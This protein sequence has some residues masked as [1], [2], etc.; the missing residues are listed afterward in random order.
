MPWYNAGTVSVTND[1]VNVTGAGTAWV[2]N[3]RAGQSFVG[4]DG[5]TIEIASVVSATSLTLARPYRGVTAAGQAYS[6]M[7][8]QGDLRDLALQAK[9]LVLSFSSV[10]DGVG[11][12]IFPVGTVGTPGIR[13][14]GDEDTGLSRTAANEL[15]GI[16]GGAVGWRLTTGGL[17]VTGAV[18]A[19]N[20]GGGRA[21]LS[22]G[23]ATHTGFLALYAANDVRRGYIG[24]ITTTGGAQPLSYQ[25]E[26][27]GVHL[28]AQG[29]TSS[30]DI[31]SN[32][33][34][35]RGDG[36]NA[37]VRPTNAG[38]DLCLGA[39]ATTTWRCA[40]S[41][42]FHPEVD[43]VWS[44]GRADKR[45]SVFF[46]GTGSINTSDEREKL[47][48][49]FSEDLKAKF[50]RIADAI[51]RELGWFQLLD[52]IEE[53]GE[54]G[55]RWHFGVRAQRVWSIVA[56]EGL[57]A[58]LIGEGA[59]QRPDPSWTGSPP[60]A[61]LCWDIWPDRFDPIME[62]RQVGTDT[63]V[64]GQ[65]PT[66]LLDATGSP[67]MRNLIEERP[68]MGMVEVGQRLDRAAGNR[69]GLRVDQMGL[70]LNWEMGERDKDRQAEV[71]EFAVRLEALEAA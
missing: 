35:L 47:W 19:K 37:F 11:Q 4:P 32:N 22:P 36:S 69:F 26:T 28:F 46:A 57:C 60:P 6:I 42:V 5:L 61:W 53:K 56:A 58:P 48:R 70:L 23:D 66:G 15:S 3:V 34:L 49:G 38:G 13:F 9:D 39:N 31:Q 44:V 64:V 25:N 41:G 40:N 7:P 68:I 54:D 65:E 10:R 24:F 43:N 27:G 71:A 55:A 33:L 8:V 21:D 2:D 59:E 63:V 20:A 17:A 14:S 1:S 45:A 29:I 67:I 51:I 30:S 16:V 12:G 62:Q 50:R 18:T 52:Q